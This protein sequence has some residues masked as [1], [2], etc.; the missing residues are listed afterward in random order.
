MTSASGVDP[1]MNVARWV[2]LVVA[3]AIVPLVWALIG[4]GVANALRELVR[5]AGAWGQLSFVLGAFVLIVLCAP[6]SLV[7]VT[8]GM[9]FGVRW[10]TLWAALAAVLGSTAAFAIARSALGARV[11][12]MLARSARLDRFEQALSE[13]GLWLTLLLR[14]SLI[15]PIGPVSYALGLSRTRATQFIATSPAVLPAVFS[16][17]YAGELAH[18]WLGHHARAREGWEWVVVALGV[19][20]TIGAAWLLA[21]AARI[22]RS[23][24]GAS[25]HG[26]R[27]ARFGRPT[28]LPAANPELLPPLTHDEQGQPRAVGVEIEFLRMEP[29]E[30]C[31]VITRLFGGEVQRIHEHALRVVGTSLGELR[32]E[33]DSH[34]LSELAAKRKRR[35]P[36]RLVERIKGAVLGAIAHEFTPSEITTAPIAC[37]RLGELDSLVHALGRAGAEGTDDGVFAVVGVHFNTTAPTR[38]ALLLRDY[39]RAY[40][41]LHE[42]L[43][44]ELHID[45]ARRAMRFATAYP[46]AYRR[47]VLAPD[48][49]PDFPALMDDYLRHNPTRNRGLD[50]LPLFA[51]ID[52]ERV[53]NATSDP[54]IKGRPA[55]HFR[56]PNSQVGTPGWRITDEWR[57]W[58]EVERLAVDRPLLAACAAAACREL[59]RSWRSKWQRWFAPAGSL[60]KERE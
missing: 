56:L 31:T 42:R 18:G 24:P 28:P 33:L 9:A 48:Y 3:L 45:P 30:A 34:A 36:V 23:A 8:A 60:Q 40:A 29:S 1:S 55:F 15:A 49:A 6:A 7:Y 20:A 26:V 53:R 35:L 22:A 44:R 51:H 47:L 17:A 27:R 46:D 2:L 37:E 59:D 52:P 57:V 11:A 25:D 58:L 14:L 41:L 5:T 10:G 4:G 13:R 32:V 54:R 43:V 12:R 38:D 21:R 16:Y 19:A 39:I 50:L